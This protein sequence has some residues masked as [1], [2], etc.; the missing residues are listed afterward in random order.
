MAGR[1]PLG[2]QFGWLWAAFAASTFGTSFA[3]DAFAVISILVL[4]AGP[5]EVSLLKA[6]GLA[7]GAALAIPLGPFVEFRRKRPVMIGMDLI[8][9][10]AVISIPLAFVSLYLIERPA[11]NLKRFILRRPAPVLTEPRATTS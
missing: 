10:A 1:R 7:A 3:F 8:R 4:Q 6:A 9:F 11:L 2:R 5:I